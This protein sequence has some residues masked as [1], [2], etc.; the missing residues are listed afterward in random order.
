M[1]SFKMRKKSLTPP[2]Q[3]DKLPAMLKILEA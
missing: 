1:N 2:K 3:S